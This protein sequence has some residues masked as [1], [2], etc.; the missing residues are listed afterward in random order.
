MFPMALHGSS[1]ARGW[2]GRFRLRRRLSIVSSNVLRR[3]ILPAYGAGP[4]LPAI[5][6]E[7][8]VYVREMSDGLYSPLTY[9]MY[10]VRPQ[11][12]DFWYWRMHAHL[13]MHWRLQSHV[14][15]E[16]VAV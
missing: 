7:R 9:L 12:A 6:M 3:V 16:K 10:K 4:Y 8:P 5:V 11:P 13:Y 15:A 1:V 2:A 14:H